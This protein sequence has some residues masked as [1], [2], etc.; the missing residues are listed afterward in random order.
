VLLAMLLSVNLQ[1]SEGQDND[2]MNRPYSQ[3]AEQHRTENTRRVM[4][5][6]I[7]GLRPGKDTADKAYHRFGEDREVRNLAAFNSAAWLDVC[8]FQM[9]TVTFDTNK[10]IRDVTIKHAPGVIDADCEIK[11]YS[12]SVRSRMGGTRHGLVFQDRCDRVEEIYG[13][14]Q[15][16]SQDHLFNKAFLYRYDFKGRSLTF[17]VTCDSD[18]EVEV[19]KLATSDLGKP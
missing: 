17:E 6:E 4:E 19:I 13:T 12:R 10:I 14:T 16:K 9:L 15:F 5:Y 11:S 7:A 18:N 8:S 1:L 2:P 3:V